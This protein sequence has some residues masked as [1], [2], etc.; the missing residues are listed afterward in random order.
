MGPMLGG[1]KVS[2]FCLMTSFLESLISFSTRTLHRLTV[3]EWPANLYELNPI[4]D[5][6]HL[7]N[8]YTGA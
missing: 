2:Y 3:L 5:E 8:Q 7:T 6:K 4:E 1:P